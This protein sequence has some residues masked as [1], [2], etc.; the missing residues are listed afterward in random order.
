M[1]CYPVVMIQVFTEDGIPPLF[2]MVTKDNWM[3]FSLEDFVRESGRIP[4]IDNPPAS[5]S[6]SQKMWDDL[7][8]DVYR[9]LS[10]CEWAIYG[11]IRG[12]LRRY[13]GLDKYGVFDAEFA[14]TYFRCRVAIATDDPSFIRKAM[15]WGQEL[16]EIP[17]P[18]AVEL[19]DPKDIP[20]DLFPQLAPESFGS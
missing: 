3:S 13:C 2:G 9:D 17:N 11:F 14:T 10:S 7:I 19:T 16:N 1:N 5:L 15:S 12:S 4:E 8:L 6:M 18:D 20:W